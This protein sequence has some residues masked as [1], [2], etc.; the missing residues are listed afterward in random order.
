MFNPQT[1]LA[2]QPV[3]TTRTLEVPP[4]VDK[5][6]AIFMDHRTNQI[7]SCLG[8][9]IVASAICIWCTHTYKT[10]KGGG[11]RPKAKE[12]FYI[13]LL[14]VLLCYDINDMKDSAYATKNTANNFKAPISKVVAENNTLSETERQLL[15]YHKAMKIK[16]Q[17]GFW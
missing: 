9:L 2:Q 5:M 14:T 12:V 8:L 15:A 10:I 17:S 3:N 7:L 11:P 4:V 6:F 16:Y 1:L 13:L